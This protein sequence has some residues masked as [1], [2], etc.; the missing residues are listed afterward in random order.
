MSA[1]MHDAG[2]GDRRDDLATYALGALDPAEAAE[3][4][5]H[6][7]SC[8]E[9]RSYLAGLRPGIDMLAASVPQV[10]PPPEL[11]DRL[12]ATVRA[13]AARIAEAEAPAAPPR[14]RWRSWR[15]L[16]LR[17]A[18]ALAAALVLI[19]GGAVGYILHGSGG[20]TESVIPAKGTTAAPP[21]SVSA[22]LRKVDGSGTLMVKRMP[23]LRG[24]DVYEVWTQH[25]TAFRPESTFVLRR[26]GTANAAVPNL[27]GASA[28]L[29]TR[30][31]HG[32]SPQPTSKPL[33]EAD[34]A[35]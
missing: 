8:P 9:C 22:S 15:G 25:G 33:L 3:L 17:P 19:V 5:R 1:E 16:V 11:R 20:A 26:N 34:L 13:E 27:D 35:G 18:T 32:G 28:V 30:E 12:L 4:E 10:P 23:P 29:V 6:L 2:H 7:A 21:G 24:G 31:P 14:R